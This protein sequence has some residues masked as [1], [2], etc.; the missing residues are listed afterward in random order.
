MKL[1]FAFLLLFLLAFTYRIPGCGDGKLYA[2]EKQTGND[3][4]FAGFPKITGKKNGPEYESG[5]KKLDQL[6]REKLVLSDEAK[7]HRFV[8]NYYFTVQC[9]GSIA[10]IVILGDPVVQEWTN[11]ENILLHTRG[12]K[13]ATVNGKPVDC[14]Y[15]RTLPINGSEFK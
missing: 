7:K 9:D 14:I 2:W 13:P 1:F 11:I 15:F 12:W 6:I 3:T 4:R 10:T 5:D 8:L